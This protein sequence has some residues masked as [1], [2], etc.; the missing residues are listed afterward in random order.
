MEP[1]C[2]PDV[3]LPPLKITRE[4]VLLVLHAVVHLQCHCCGWQL[5]PHRHLELPLWDT[6]FDYLCGYVAEDLELLVGQRTCCK[7]GDEVVVKK[8]LSV[9][10]CLQ[11]VDVSPHLHLKLLITEDQTPRFSFSKLDDERLSSLPSTI[12]DADL[13]ESFGRVFNIG[14]VWNALINHTLEK[15]EVSYAE[16][17][18]GYAIFCAPIANG[19]DEFDND[20]KKVVQSLCSKFTQKSVLCSRD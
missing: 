4:S 9:S 17:A 12:S 8:P 1:L 3:A 19:Q 6:S 13:Y 18:P 10:M 14:A 11:F 16:V 2:T 15:G 5:T 20:A 7:C